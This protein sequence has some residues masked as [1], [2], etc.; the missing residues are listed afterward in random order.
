M[1]YKEL[2]RVWTVKLTDV[3]KKEV[4]VLDGP[5]SCYDCSKKVIYMD[6]KS[7]QFIAD[8]C[9]VYFEEAYFLSLAHEYGHFLSD[10]NGTLGQGGTL[11]EETRAWKNA[12]QALNQMGID[13][14]TRIF[15]KVETFCLF[16]YRVFE[17]LNQL[18]YVALAV[19]SI[20]CVG[21]GVVEW[22]A[23]QQTPQQQ[24]QQLK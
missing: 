8:K 1:M 21:I 14:P 12:R 10:K 19:V 15:N 2:L 18:P 5:V 9:G 17:R 16:I 6:T 22:T 4:P 13:F 23:P 20:L 3:I 7:I 24:Q 11:T